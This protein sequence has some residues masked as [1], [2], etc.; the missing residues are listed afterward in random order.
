MRVGGFE[1]GGRQ[2]DMVH[3]LYLPNYAVGKTNPVPK[4]MLQSC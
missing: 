2:G 3:S 4:K 1:A